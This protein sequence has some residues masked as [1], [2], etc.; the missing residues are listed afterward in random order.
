MNCDLQKLGLLFCC[1]FC[2]KGLCFHFIQEVSN[3]MQGKDVCKDG[4]ES[5]FRPINVCVFS[6][7]IHGKIIGKNVLSIR[8]YPFN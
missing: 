5:G 4:F 1:E 7:K 3:M 8:L 6:L 2:P